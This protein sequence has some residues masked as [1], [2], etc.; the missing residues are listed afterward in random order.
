MTR[1]GVLL[2]SFRFRA[3]DEMKLDYMKKLDENKKTYLDRCER[4]PS[5]HKWGIGFVKLIPCQ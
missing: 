4:S 3:N 2:Y 5:G 1:D